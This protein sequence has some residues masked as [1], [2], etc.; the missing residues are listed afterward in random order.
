MC[1]DPRHGE[2][3]WN[4][5]GLVQGISDFPLNH[6]GLEQAGRLADQLRELNISY[7][8]SSDQK[9]AR[10]TAQIV[11]SVCGCNLTVHSSLREQN[12]GVA[13]GRPSTEIRKAHSELFSVID[14]INHEDTNTTSL[15][16]AE[17]RLEVF[18]RAAG[19]LRAFLSQ[20]HHE[21][22]GVSTHGGVILSLMSVQFRQMVQIGNG[23]Y[24]TLLYNGNDFYD[25]EL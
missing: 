19:Q 3:D 17:T 9:R 11:A 15:P 6:R 10:Q 16:E 12:F 1:L 24:L 2:T 14:D 8:F 4:K 7:I 25:F 21:T 13:E 22:I 20:A 18:N 23:E 5:R